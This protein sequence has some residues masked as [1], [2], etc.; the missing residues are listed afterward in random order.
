MRAQGCGI[1]AIHNILC[2]LGKEKYFSTL[3]AEFDYNMITSGKNGVFI[4]TLDSCLDSYVKSKYCEGKNK[5]ETNIKNRKYGIIR[6]VWNGGRC[7]F[8]CNKI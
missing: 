5:I 1:V 6:V 8:Y 2:L 7:A 3:V 4:G